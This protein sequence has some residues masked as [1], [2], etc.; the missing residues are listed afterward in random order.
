M[1]DTTDIAIDPGDGIGEGVT[2]V[3]GQHIHVL[4][5]PCIVDEAFQD[6]HQV[7]HRYPFPQEVLQHFLDG[8]GRKQLGREL[9]HN[10]GIILLQVFDQ[11][12]CVLA[13]EDPVG[14]PPEELLQMGGEDR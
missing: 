13:P 8:P 11:L 14:V 2:D 1:D 7:A 9:V 10:G 6:G 12:A 3:F 4:R 5:H